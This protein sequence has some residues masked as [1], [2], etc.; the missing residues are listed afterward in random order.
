MPARC[1]F[2]M[3]LLLATTIVARA[4][5]GRGNLVLEAIGEPASLTISAPN[6]ISI[7]S[8][9]VLEQ[10]G[11]SGWEPQRV[12]VS[13]LAKCPITSSDAPP[14]QCVDI[15]PNRPLAAVPWQGQLCASQCSTRCRN[16]RINVGHYRYVARSCDGTQVFRSNVF[17]IGMSV[18]DMVDPD[19]GVEPRR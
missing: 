6:T 18:P 11:P 13:A 2:A 19:A 15:L 17:I 9:I 1:R 8:R 16:D 12:Q 14:P 4:E 10:A 7:E 5:D 3:A